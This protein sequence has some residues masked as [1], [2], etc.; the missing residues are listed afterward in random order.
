ML[1][2]LIVNWLRGY[3]IRLIFHR[4][5]PL[6]ISK[7]TSRK[8]NLHY[9]PI[10]PLWYP[11]KSPIVPLHW[12]HLP[13]SRQRL[14][15]GGHCEA[16]RMA[17]ARLARCRWH[18]GGNPQ[19]GGCKILWKKLW[20]D[21]F[22]HETWWFAGK[23]THVFPMKKWWFDGFLKWDNPVYKWSFYINRFNR[24]T[25]EPTMN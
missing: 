23:T 17:R 25:I 5:S 8:K 14:C 6:I 20:F 7:K 3:K 1:N 16:G 2:F 4:L 18:V 24:K 22:F 9:I 19:R 13:R 15:S 11:Y 12:G 21:V 10:I